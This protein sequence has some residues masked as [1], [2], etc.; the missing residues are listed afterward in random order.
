MSE[1]ISVQ[2]LGAWTTFALRHRPMTES[3]HTSF[4]VGR[5]CFVSCCMVLVVG[6]PQG[7][8]VVLVVAVIVVVTHGVSECVIAKVL[9]DVGACSCWGDLSSFSA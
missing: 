4:G 3:A 5:C 7:D 8:G 2:E 1:Q 9:C 6:G